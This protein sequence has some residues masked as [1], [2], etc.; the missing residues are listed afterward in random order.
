[1]I[2]NILKRGCLLVYPELFKPKLARLI[3]TERCPLRCQMCTFWTKQSTDPSLDL[4][5]HWIHECADFGIRDISLGG[6]EPF[7]RNDLQEIV[8][9]VHKYG[10]SCGITTSGCF[11]DKKRIPRGINHIEVSIDGLNPQTHDK[12]RGKQGSW[13]LAMN[14]VKEA[15]QREISLQVNY[16]IQPDNYLEFPD[17]CRMMKEICVNVSVIPISLKLAAQSSISERIGDF[18]IETVRKSI[19][20][21]MSIGNVLTNNIYID[22]IMS[23]TNSKTRCLAPYLGLLIFA[24]SELYCCGNMDRGC[25]KLTKDKKL[26]DIYNGYKQIRKEIV[27]GNH[28]FCNK[29]C[30]Y[31]DIVLRDL[32]YNIRLFL[33]KFKQ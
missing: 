32:D 2:K 4:V 16:C 15:K 33:E 11:Y 29:E 31:P 17:F 22:S 23:K 25:G 27:S 26:K 14:T 18:N 5:K 30:T 19:K 13:Q 9:E 12:I 1:M 24:D 10:M 21:G 6:G 3:I 7:I 28:E 20:E 8:D